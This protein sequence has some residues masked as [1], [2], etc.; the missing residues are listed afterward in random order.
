MRAAA[1]ALALQLAC[2]ESCLAIKV[3][4][5]LTLGAEL[6]SVAV[7]ADY[8][9][10]VAELAGLAGGKLVKKL[11]LSTGIVLSDL[12]TEGAWLDPD[13]KVGPLD[14]RTVEG[15]VV[16]WVDESGLA[17]DVA[18]WRALADDE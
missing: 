17:P 6:H 8:N 7:A 11:K 10:T 12:E 18:E 16:G 5:R 2:L 1:T 3:S 15:Q 13:D 4:C 9:A 14:L